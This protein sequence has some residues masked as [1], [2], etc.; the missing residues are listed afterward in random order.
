MPDDSRITDESR[1][2]DKGRMPYNEAS[3][4]LSQ[5]S[6]RPPCSDWAKSQHLDPIGSA[7]Y[8][9]GFLLVEQPLP[10]PADVSEMA[11][12]LEVAKVAYGARLRLQ[13]VAWAGRPGADGPAA[14]E[15]PGQKTAETAETAGTGGADGADGA[16]GAPRR[17]ICYRSTRPGWA[18]RMARSERLAEPGLLAEAA[19]A[20]VE[21]AAA[22]PEGGVG[23]ATADVLVCTHGRRD[24]C[25]GARGMELL[26]ALAGAPTFGQPG[27]RVWRT[28][29]TG[30]HRFAPTAIALPSASLWAWTDAALL[31]Q[32]VDAEGPLGSA[33]SRYRGCASLGSPAQQAVEK[34]VLSEVGWPLLSS[35]RRAAD[36]GGGLVRLDTELYGTWEA[37]AR[38]GRRVAQPDCRSDPGLA[39]KQSVEWVVEGLRQVVAA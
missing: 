5:I 2:P 33:I 19:H 15:R 10:W 18:G 24:A 13:A 25:C 32:V 34:A 38:E 17:V 14:A 26:G 6:W 27:V 1:A 12:L 7:G 30:G 22:A 35:W 20:V 9:D 4:G 37:V 16:D 23:G 28:S 21:E 29:H 11:E 36:L 39:T 31:S 3:V 8:Y